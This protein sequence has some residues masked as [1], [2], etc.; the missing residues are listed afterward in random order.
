MRL[1]SAAEAVA[2]I[3]SGEQVYVHAAAAAPSVLLDA[4]VARAPELRDVRMLHLHIEGPGPHLAPE[5][6]GHFFHRALFIG[7]NARRAVNE[8]RAEYIP[9]F[10]SDIPTLFR[11]GILP[12]DAVLINVSPP[13]RHGYCS[14]G[15][16][17]VALP[18]AI[19]VA[20]TVIAQ[21][22]RAMPRTLGDSFVH[23]D[24]IDLG[25][26]VDVP[27]YGH[28]Y[29]EI[30]D[31]ERRIG[32]HV[33]DLVPDGATLQM[34]IGAIPT[35][36]AEGLRDK[37][38]LGVHTEMMTDVVLDLVESGVV[39]GRAKEINVGK[40]V[41]TFMLGSQRLYDW[42]DDNPMVEMRPVEYTNDTA[43]IRRFSRMVAVN[44]A[45]EVDLTGQVCADSMG[46][47]MYSGVGGQMD[48]I[49]GAALADEGRAIIALPS[50]AAGD[51]VSRIVPFLRE[52]A[53]VVTTRA[54]VE[55]IVTEWGVAE[56]QG[57]SIPERA[58]ALIAIADPR[59][60]DQLEHEARKVN[61]L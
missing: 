29:G 48:F 45:I 28:A 51:T 38:D 58:R 2:G 46:A 60:R 53:G 54:H 57:R 56:M 16:S 27:P 47:R 49:R 10:L 4:L 22:N 17:V 25:V 23:V 1:V 26:E 12:L 11:R 43:V 6:A 39:T 41:A 5:M 21:V 8:G 40:I 15:T 13:D 52:G 33:A 61:W 55:T 24:D 14:M 36:V 42:V 18:S 32:Q 31:V 50:T 3:R 9:A 35:A 34:G 59:F 44:S 20:R 19:R 30:G 7:P 37:R